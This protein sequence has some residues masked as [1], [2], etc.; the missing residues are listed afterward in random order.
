MTSST[1]NYRMRLK[2]AIDSVFEPV[3][4]T[5]LES[6]DVNKSSHNKIYYNLDSFTLKQIRNNSKIR[7]V[8]SGISGG[9]GVGIDGNSNIENRSKSFGRGRLNASSHLGDLSRELSPQ[10]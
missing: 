9:I 1:N 2:S 7:K 5:N 4:K 10:K 3:V 8:G 6:I